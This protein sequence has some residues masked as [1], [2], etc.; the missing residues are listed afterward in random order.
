M[1]GFV[2]GTAS[3]AALQKGDY[4]LYKNGP[5]GSWQEGPTGSLRMLFAGCS[6]VERF[7]N[8][9]KSR[10]DALLK[11]RTDL[12][13]GLQFFEI[14][15]TARDLDISREAAL[16]FEELLNT[17]LASIDILNVLYSRPLAFEFPSERRDFF[18]KTAPRFAYLISELQRLRPNIQEVEA[19]IMQAIK[20]SG[21]EG[22][23]DTLLGR[24]I[25]SGSFRQFVIQGYVPRVGVVSTTR[26]SQAPSNFRDYDLTIPVEILGELR[27]RNTYADRIQAARERARANLP[28]GFLLGAISLLLIIVQMILHAMRN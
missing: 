24:L 8:I 28:T 4:L 22:M 18:Q 16:R 19:R 9:D 25:L 20:K 23:T 17:S 26:H 27:P 5:N 7:E 15:L 14:A 11:L 13:Y 2:S 1:V 10:L 3:R 6:D 21:S 12:Q